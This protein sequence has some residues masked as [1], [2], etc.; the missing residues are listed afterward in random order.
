MRGMA[1]PVDREIATPNRHQCEP[2]PDRLV[3][4]PAR[5]GFDRHIN[6]R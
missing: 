1:D 6:P 2:N 3:Q 5:R 4:D